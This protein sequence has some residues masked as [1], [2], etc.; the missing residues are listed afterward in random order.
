MM[1]NLSFILHFILSLAIT[2]GAIYGQELQRDTTTFKEH[3][4]LFE[5]MEFIPS[6]RPVKLIRILNNDT[7]GI[8]VLSDPYWISCLVSNKEYKEYLQAIESRPIQYQTALPPQEIYSENIEALDVVYQEYFEN[9]EFE[10]FPVLGIS[11]EQARLFCSWKTQ[12]VNNEL[13]QAGLPHEKKYRLPLASE[14]E[15]AKHYTSINMPR[16]F[17]ETPSVNTSEII[18]FNNSLDE[19][20]LESFYESTYLKKLSFVETSPHAVIYQKM[21]QYQKPYRKKDAHDLTIG[22]RYAQ[23]YRKVP[24]PDNY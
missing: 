1:K 12:Q 20:T 23:T 16:V 24:V 4:V 18:R 6:H 13:D 10:H 11:W 3:Q 7:A 15:G 8:E 5:K 22:F 14:I 9:K 21:S 17:K 2:T 19:W